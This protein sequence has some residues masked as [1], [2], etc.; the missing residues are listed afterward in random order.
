MPRLCASRS[1]A[2]ASSLQPVVRT[3]G[4]GLRAAARWRCGGCP[5]GS[6]RRDRAARNWPCPTPGRPGRRRR[7]RAAA[8]GARRRRGRPRAAQS[9]SALA[10][11]ALALVWPE[12]LMRL[13]SWLI[14]LATARSSSLARSLGSGRALVEHR[15]AFLVDQLDAQAFGRL[16]DHDVLRQLGQ[17]RHVLQ[18]L[19]QRLGGRGEGGFLAPRQGFAQGLGAGRSSGCLAVRR[20]RPSLGLGDSGAICWMTDMRAGGLGRRRSP[21]AVPPRMPPAPEVVSE[22]LA[23][24]K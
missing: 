23:G 4:P 14:T 7:R 11:L 9:L 2:G 20:S 3:A 13:G 24:A 18:R 22:T 21:S 8:P 15:A 5:A 17:F 12:M 6:D 16:V 10:P 19:A 1:T